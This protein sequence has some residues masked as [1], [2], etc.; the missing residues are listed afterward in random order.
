MCVCRLCVCSLCVCSLCVCSMCVCNLC[1]CSLCVCRL[2]VCKQCVCSSVS[3]VHSVVFEARGESPLETEVAAA[4]N[5]IACMHGCFTSYPCVT[6]PVG[7]PHC[8]LTALLSHQRHLQ[9][10]K[11]GVHHQS[12]S[13]DILLQAFKSH[14]NSTRYVV[15]LP[16]SPFP[17]CMHPVTLSLPR[18]PSV[19]SSGVCRQLHTYAA[20]MLAFVS[21]DRWSLLLEPTAATN[22]DIKSTPQLPLSP[23]PLLP[24]HPQQSTPPTSSLA[25]SSPPLPHLPRA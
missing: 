2:C 4:T 21:C 8:E 3:C 15:N 22:S 19:L 1:V 6:L 10:V 13:L 11:S 12:T 24:R 18:L 7:T 14:S 16:P 20:P 17:S 23:S 9:W 5:H 25:S